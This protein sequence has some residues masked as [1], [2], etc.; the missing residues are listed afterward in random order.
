MN[1]VPFISS[2]R[3][4]AF[5]P[6]VIVLTVGLT[7]T[8]VTTWGAWEAED[9][10]LQEV[11]EQ[12]VETHIRSLE[13]GLSQRLHQ[14]EIVR[15]F[16]AVSE[17][18]SQADFKAFLDNMDMQWQGVAAIAW[19]PWKGTVDNIALSYCE[20]VEIC[21]PHFAPLAER[22]IT[23]QTIG[24][25]VTAV[26]TV[27]SSPTPFDANGTSMVTLV[28]APVFRRGQRQNP[29]E[30]LGIV[31][32][33][34]VLS[35]MVELILNEQ[36]VP[37]GLDLYFFQDTADHTRQLVYYHPTRTHKTPQPPLSEVEV[38]RGPHFLH[39]I[40]MADSSLVLVV[41][42]VPDAIA[43]LQTAEPLVI[44][45]GGIL[46]TVLLA[47]YMLES[48]RHTARIESTVLARTAELNAA[49]ALLQKAKNQAE[50]ADRAKTRFLAA[51]SHDLRQ[52]LQALN[53]FV[54]VLS[55]RD[56]DADTHEIIEHIRE[57]TRALENLLNSLLDI[58]KLDAGLV[59]PELEEVP[60]QDLFTRL[61]SQF[62]P[63]A[64]AKDLG[65]KIVPLHL[66]LHTDP[67]L[68]E[69]ILRN[70]LSNAVRYTESGE[71]VLSCRRD[72]NLALLNVHDTG[73]GIPDDQ[74]EAIFQEFLRLDREG[75]DESEGIGLGLAIVERLARLLGH[76]VRVVS[77]VGKGTSFIVEVPIAGELT[78][79]QIAGAKDL[80]AKVAEVRVLVVDDEPNVLLAMKNQLD[81][82]GYTVQVARSIGQA[83]EAIASDDATPNLILADYR[84]GIGITGGDAIHAIR[85]YLGVKVPGILITGDTAPERLRE[86]QSSGFRLLHKPVPPHEL[87]RAMIDVIGDCG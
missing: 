11:I 80:T 38:L 72:G 30:L 78:E 62:A 7:L 4:R 13:N 53:L 81:N 67:A 47:A 12:R 2:T 50:E 15:G 48:L 17:D 86:A 36:T 79:V 75:S 26:R 35:D 49:N 10:R 66:T 5:L 56:H 70:L 16:L 46:V 3:F 82:W 39:R 28:A 9:R 24:K 1:F 22:L 31:L 29:E 73:P 40:L 27:V 43:K 32:S 44:L 84:L 51:A 20:P 77:K 42:P 83:L 57:S 33:M 41:R 25:A 87:R 76:R 14:V 8:T 59:L 61:R 45:V 52:P 54:N 64:E 69:S 55:N 74:R 23:R 65:L 19:V 58:S 68:I 18:M 37:S 63:L 60:V 6:T 71:I 21:I 85:D 34:F